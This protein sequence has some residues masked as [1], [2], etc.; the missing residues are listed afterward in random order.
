VSQFVQRL[1]PS[2][3]PE[4][5]WVFS[6]VQLRDGLL[7][8]PRPASAFRERGWRL[9]SVGRLEPEKGHAV[10]VDAVQQLVA[11]GLGPLQL[12]LIG[13]G[14]ELEA[15]RAQVARLRLDPCVTLTGRVEWGPAL[16]E[17]LDAADL[18]VLP[19]LTEGM[20]RALIEALARGVPA[21]GTNAGG[22]PEL[23]PEAQVVRP[24]DPAALAELIRV[25]LHDRERLAAMSRDGFERALEYAPE[26]MRKR[27]HAFWRCLQECVRAGRAGDGTAQL[28]TAR[29][30]P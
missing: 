25:V 1:Y 24:G 2:R 19:S 6:G 9:V 30:E 14:R 21:V 10:L 15:L 16:W 12:T 3:R 27:K 7:R 23:L 13:P 18:F 20:P 29:G 11:G 5:E 28:D 4:R 17:Y 8:G 26:N 22:I